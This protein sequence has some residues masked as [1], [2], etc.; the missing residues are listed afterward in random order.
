MPFKDPEKRRLANAE[1]MRRRRAEGTAWI[2][3]VKEAERKARWYHEDGGKE[4]IVA[5]NR[6]RRQQAKEQ[7]LLNE[8]RKRK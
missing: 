7:G 2:D 1:R 4:K 5:C 6:Q 8:L 3:P